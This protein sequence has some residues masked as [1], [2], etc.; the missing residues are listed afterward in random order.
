MWIDIRPTGVK[1]SF[2]SRIDAEV[3]RRG[4]RNRL[5]TCVVRDVNAELSI[6]GGAII[7]NP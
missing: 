5:D 2:W 6:L 4:E 1:A 7:C 3:L